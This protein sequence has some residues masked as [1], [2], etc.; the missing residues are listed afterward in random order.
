M[1][2]KDFLTQI[3]RSDGEIQ[4]KLE[5]WIREAKIYQKIT[6]DKINQIRL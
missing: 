2:P 1:Y 5:E 3:V 6:L 4:K